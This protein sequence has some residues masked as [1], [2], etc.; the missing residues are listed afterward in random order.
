[1]S[2]ERTE[3][4]RS[5]WS[6]YDAVIGANYMFHREIHA[7]IRRVLGRRAGQGPYTLLDL[8]CGNAR[9]LAGALREYQP[10][11]YL[12]VDLSRSALDEAAIEL[13]GLGGVALRELDMVAAAEELVAAGERFDV[14][15]SGFAMHHLLAP[16]KTRLFKLLGRMM[17]PGGCLLLVDLVREAGQTREAYLDGYLGTVRKG[18]RLLDAGQVAEVCRHVSAYDF[19]ETLQDLEAMAS[20]ANFG[21]CAVLG[22]FAQHGVIEFEAG[23]RRGGGA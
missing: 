19:P 22:Q 9:G 11:R 4:F 7:I 10:V 12:G 14:V 3:I 13:S 15:Y 21:A 16:E 1:M 20:E 6:L 2:D 5:S 8:G 23:L 18:W 17:N